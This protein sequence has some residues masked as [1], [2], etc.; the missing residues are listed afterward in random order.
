[1]RKYPQP[2]Y[3][4]VR[5][6]KASRSYDCS[7]RLSEMN[8]PTLILHGKTDKFARYKLVEEMHAGIKG[9]KIITFEG[10]HRFFMWGNIRFTDAISE[11]LESIG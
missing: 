5:Q 8:V 10:G 1:M 6:L 7:G 11:F 9:S 2:Y 3:A 4:F